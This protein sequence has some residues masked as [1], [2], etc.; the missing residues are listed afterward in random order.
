[1]INVLEIASAVGAHRCHIRYKLGIIEQ[2]VNLR[3][4]L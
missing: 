1:M 2:K 4:L 3:T